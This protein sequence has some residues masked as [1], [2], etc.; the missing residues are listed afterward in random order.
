MKKR[1]ERFLLTLTMTL[2]ERK[3]GNWLLTCLVK[4]RKK[5]MGVLGRKMFVWL[6]LSQ[7]YMVWVWDVLGNILVFC[8]VRWRE[9]VC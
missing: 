4:N 9:C 5:A 2:R 8:K 7:S 1:K 3:D 6:I